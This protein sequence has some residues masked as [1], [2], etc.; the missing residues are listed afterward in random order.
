MVSK[1]ELDMAKEEAE[2]KKQHDLQQV[3]DWALEKKLAL[4]DGRK[5]YDEICQQITDYFCPNRDNFVVKRSPGEDRTRR[6]Y[7]PIGIQCV[8]QASADLYGLLTDP[9]GYWFE[10]NFENQ[11]SMSD[12]MKYWLRKQS[13][14]IYEKLYAPAARAAQALARSYHD[15]LAYGTDII[16]I[17]WNNDRA[18]P[19]LQN[20]RLSECYIDEDDTGLVDTLIR[21]YELSV[22]SIKQLYPK[23]ELS[24]EMLEDIRKNKTEKKYKIIHAVFPSSEHT[25]KISKMPYTSLIFT[26]KDKVVLETSG[27][28]EFPFAV[29]RWETAPGEV[30]GRSKAMTAK[31]DVL[32]LQLMTKEMLESAQ[33]ANR[34]MMA[35]KHSEER[36]Q[37]PRI[38]PGGYME[39]EDEPPIAFNAGN[40][41]KAADDVIQRIEERVKHEFSLYRINDL[42]GTHRTREEILQRISE[43]TRLLG[44]VAG[45]Q[46]T[47]KLDVILLRVF[48]LCARNGVLE[49]P[50]EDVPF[51][52]LKVV[53]NSPIAKMMK[54][55]RATRYE[56]AF[57]SMNVFLQLDPSGIDNISTDII[58]REISSIYGVPELL[59]SEEEVKT[60]RDQRAQAQAQA[61]N[62]NDAMTGLQMQGMANQVLGEQ[63]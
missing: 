53:Y 36:L 52:D 15:D 33:L 28:D 14:L 7:N 46:M 13:E 4:E 1:I 63:P 11:D 60:I 51:F 58:M 16:Y 10:F 41:Y 55:E 44:P 2:L 54:Y 42:Q 24:F 49:P 39:Y 34:P 6:I 40:N 3:V 35:I 31:A 19:L 38:T 25:T 20:L 12:N 9:S 62:V 29:C 47:E 59:R 17:G 27:Y 5:N 45:R 23:A 18:C 56:Q 30:Y 8:E 37:I 26:E 57:A 32:T 48:N 22:K 43:G 61:Q 50:P 21:C